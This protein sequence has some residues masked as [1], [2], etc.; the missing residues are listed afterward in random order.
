MNDI[1]IRQPAQK[2]LRFSSEGM[3]G[4]QIE[5]HIESDHHVRVFCYYA[6]PPSERGGGGERE[7]MMPE[8][9]VRNYDHT[10][11]IEWLKSSFWDGLIIR[12]VDEVRVKQFLHDAALSFWSK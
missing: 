1:L 5:L 7:R 10:R 9:L 6:P 2:V 11:F 4:D 8:E 12:P 3:L